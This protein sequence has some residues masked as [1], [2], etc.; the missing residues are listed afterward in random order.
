MTSSQPVGEATRCRRSR[1]RARRGRSRRP[2]GRARSG[3]P[4]RPGSRP[5]RGAPRTRSSRSLCPAGLHLGVEAG[6]H[7]RGPELELPRRALGA[8]EVRARRSPCRRR[9]CRRAGPARRRGRC[10]GG[11]RPRGPRSGR[12]PPAPRWRR[13][14]PASWSAA[15]WER[16]TIMPSRFIS[17]TTSTPNRLSPPDDGVVGRGVGPG[18]VVVVGERQVADAEL[19]EHPQ[20]AQRAADRVAA[21]GAE[22]RGDPAVAPGGLHLVGRGRERQPVGVP[23]DEAVGAVDLLQGGGDGRVARR[24]WWG[25]RPTRTGRPPRPRPAAAGRCGWTGVAAD[26]EPVEVVADLL[27][28]LP[29]QV[30]VAVDD[31]VAGEQRRSRARSMG[32]TLRAGTICRCRALASRSSPLHPSGREVPAA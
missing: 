11:R 5:A 7:A 4:R 22:Q 19:V 9:R 1:R 25:R 32:A 21:L 10:A 12:R 15:T 20:R 30:V 13:A 18:G 17:R 14:P 28:R 24:S 26:V 29:Q 27:A 2:R 31:G 6:R 16:S 3:R 8:H 23:L